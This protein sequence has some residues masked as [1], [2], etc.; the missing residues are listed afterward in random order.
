MKSVTPITDAIGPDRVIHIVQNMIRCRAQ[1]DPEAQ[2]SLDDAVLEFISRN[3]LALATLMLD[4]MLPDAHPDEVEAI[5][6]RAHNRASVSG[7]ERV[8]RHAM[9]AGYFDLFGQAKA[10]ATEFLTRS[11]R[12]GLIQMAGL[13]RLHF[14]GAIRNGVELRT[15][16]LVVGPSGTGKSKWPIASRLNLAAFPCSKSPMELGSSVAH[17]LRCP[18]FSAFGQSWKRTSAC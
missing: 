13:A 18:P 12:A 6:R 9:E 3:S 8:E 1:L 2:G 11:Q 16:P 17:G 4:R 15:W 14:D 7:R 10:K 5:L